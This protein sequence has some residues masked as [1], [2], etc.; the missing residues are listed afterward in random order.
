[1]ALASCPSSASRILCTC[2]PLLGVVLIAAAPAM[3]QLS[4]PRCGWHYGVEIT[5]QNSP[6]N[7]CTVPSNDS[8][9]GVRLA[10]TRSPLAG[11]VAS[12]LRRHRCQPC[13]LQ[14]R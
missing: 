6:F 13:S 7:G 8:P 11:S 12:Q 3:A 5:P 4:G 2:S 10:K 14:R 1:M 9:Y